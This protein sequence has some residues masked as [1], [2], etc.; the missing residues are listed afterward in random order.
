MNIRAAYY[1]SPEAATEDRWRLS[2]RETAFLAGRMTNGP[3][4]QA[5]ESVYSDQARHRPNSASTANKDAASDHVMEKFS[6][7]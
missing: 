7:K 4:G 2:L 5:L 1:E 3:M 6:P